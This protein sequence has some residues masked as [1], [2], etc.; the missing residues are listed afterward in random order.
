MSVSEP[1]KLVKSRTFHTRRG[2]IDNQFT[3][4]FLSVLVPVHKQA[5]SPNRI[6]RMGRF[7]LF[8]FYTGDV[9]GLGDL[10]DYAKNLA[11]EHGFE[12]FSQD[13]IYLLTQP[14][15]LGFVFNPVN[16]WYF[17]DSDADI[18][19]VLAEVNNTFGERHS[20][21]VRHDDF[22]PIKAENRIRA[23]KIFHV[24]PFQTVQGQYDFR[25][26]WKAN[27]LRVII[28]Y[29]NGEQGVL[30][31]QLGQ[32]QRMTTARLI[33]YFIRLPLGSLRV[34][35]LIHWQALKLWRKKAP[36]NTLPVQKEERISR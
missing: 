11:A 18:R 15:C 7:G 23:K 25:F 32:I 28:D 17:L 4:N 34:L 29:K 22:A 36:Y 26:S 35:F 3:Y 31:T 13:E 12:H 30:A 2:E 33:K 10:T 8:S 9:G 5:I 20:Y 27:Q 16:F 21:I 24:S 1:I 14:R 6:F 19:V